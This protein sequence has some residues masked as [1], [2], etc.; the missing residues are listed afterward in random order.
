ME[1]EAND[2]LVARIQEALAGDKRV[3]ELEL[4]VSVAG[5]RVLVT[6]TVPTEERRELVARVVRETAPD[7]TVVNETTV[8]DT[9][10]GADEER[11]G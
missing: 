2:Y 10:R 4:Q 5:D 11:L 3:G 1:A 8:V 6:G 9:D 7:R